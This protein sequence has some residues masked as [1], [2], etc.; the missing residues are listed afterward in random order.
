MY[1]NDEYIIEEMYYVEEMEEDEEMYYNEKP[2][3]NEEKLSTKEGIGAVILFLILM[4][5]LPFVF[6]FLTIYEIFKSIF[7]YGRLP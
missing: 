6:I 3:R 5:I 7:L 2:E 4:P 1:R